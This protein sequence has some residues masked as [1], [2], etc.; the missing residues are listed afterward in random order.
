[1]MKTIANHILHNV[2]DALA[3]LHCE[4]CDEKINAHMHIH[5]ICDGCL[6]MFECAPSNEE[7]LNGLYGQNNADTYIS[8]VESFF[9]FH[10]EAPIQKALYAIKYTYAKRMAQDFG[11]YVSGLTTFEGID[12]FIPVPLHSARKRER[13]YNQSMAICEGLKAKTKIPISVALERIR[14]SITQTKFSSYD[15]SRNVQGIFMVNNT[16]SIHGKHIMLID[17]IMTTGSTL[18][19][20]AQALL[21][22]GARLVSALTIATATLPKGIQ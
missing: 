17:D 3:P 11:Q 14:Y 6:Y 22:S 12:C 18:E 13:G 10:S 8:H 4:I 7:L 16:E 2:L 19:S 20:C 15:R 9:A 21:E 5:R 1:M